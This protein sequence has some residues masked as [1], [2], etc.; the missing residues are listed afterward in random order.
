MTIIKNGTLVLPDGVRRG[1]L[2]FENGVITKIAPV[3][4]ASAQ[5]QVFDCLLYTSRCV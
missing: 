5:D 2:A 4:E 3:L 1:E